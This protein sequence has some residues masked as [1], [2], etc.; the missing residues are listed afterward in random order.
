MLIRMTNSPAS[1]YDYDLPAE[2]IAQHP[3]PTRVDSRLMLVRRDLQTIDHY[4][5]RDLPE[6]L[7]AGDML[8]VNDSRVLPARL[9]GRRTATGGRWQGLYLEHDESGNWLVLGKT[10]GKIAA[11]EYVTLENEHGRPHTRLK[12]LARQD[13]GR[14]VVQPESQLDTIDILTAVGRIPLPHYIRDGE[15]TDE[16]RERYQTVYANE[17]G[18]IA[19]PT[20]GLH[21]NDQL[22]KRLRAAEIHRETVTLHVGMGTFRPVSTESLDDHVMHSEWG[23]VTESTAAAIRSVRAAEGRCIAVG[24]T[25]VRTLES[26]AAS[27]TSGALA[28]WRGKTDLFIRPPYEF[29]SID[30]LITNFHLPKST[31]LVLVRTFGGDALMKRAYQEA[32]DEEYRF[33]SYGDAM[34]IL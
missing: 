33:Y 10:R 26:A 18:S 27:S 30:G 14:W 29:K 2:L 5:F 15:M 20:A 13:G 8:V 1:E 28:E 11:G 3:L 21:F 9:V 16:D 24:T 7:R 19:A 4:H 17:P 34:L 32:I 12:L 23:Q 31:L 6:L 25:S 22:L